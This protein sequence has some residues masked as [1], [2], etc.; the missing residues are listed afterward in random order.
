MEAYKATDD[1]RMWAEEEKQAD[2]G[3]HRDRP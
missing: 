3:A 2:T 1:G